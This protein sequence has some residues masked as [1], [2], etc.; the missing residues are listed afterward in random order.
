MILCL[1]ASYATERPKKKK[2]TATKKPRFI[3]GIECISTSF[4]F[5]REW[6]CIIWIYH[7]SFIHAL[8]DSL[9]VSTFWLLW[10]FMNEFLS[11]NLFSFLLGLYVGVKLLSPMVTLSSTFWGTTTIFQSI[12][13]SSVCEFQFLLI[14]VSTC[15]CLSFYY[16]HHS[17]CD[18]VSSSF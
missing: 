15:Y 1:G 6:Y 3:H 14:L 10:T 16:S 4:L 9:V 8:V 7:I 2:K 17:G 12:P 5:M 18:G 11:G 13:T